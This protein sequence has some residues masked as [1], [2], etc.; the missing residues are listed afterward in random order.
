MGTHLLHEDIVRIERQ[1]CENALVMWKAHRMYN[2]KTRAVIITSSQNTYFLCRSE[3]RGKWEK[4]DNVGGG[5]GRARGSVFEN[6]LSHLF[7]TSIWTM[8]MERKTRKVQAV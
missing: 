7:V 3:A 6:Q 8:K 1:A 4:E 2:D 5:S